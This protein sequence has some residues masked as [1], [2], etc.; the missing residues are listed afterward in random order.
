[1]LQG[2]MSARAMVGTTEPCSENLIH[3]MRQRVSHSFYETEIIAFIPWDKDYLIHSMRQR[4]SHSFH[5]TKII[6]FIPWDKII[7]FIPWN[8]LSHSFHETEIISFI[9][10][11]RDYLIYSMRQRL[12]HSFHETEIISFIPWVKDDLIHSMRQRLSHSFHGTEIISFIP[13]DYVNL[14]WLFDLDR[15]ICSDGHYSASLG[16]LRDA[17]SDPEG[18]VFLSTPNGHDKFLFLHTVQL[19]LLLITLKCGKLLN[20]RIKIN[21]EY[22]FAV[23]V[24]HNAIAVRHKDL[25]LRH[26]LL[27]SWISVRIPL[28]GRI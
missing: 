12:S 6:P 20:Q 21:A 23:A 24:I 28:V 22:I 3:F 27:R 25:S 5:E 2:S 16:L 8:R 13:W 11:D 26:F 14:S 17:N 19:S 9:P 7:S 18:Q 1:M 10:L 4:L 15:K